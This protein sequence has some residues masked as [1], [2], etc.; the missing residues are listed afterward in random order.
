MLT[1][2]IIRVIYSIIVCALIYGFIMFIR[3]AKRAIKAL[4][5]YIANN[6]KPKDADESEVKK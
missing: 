5:I 1:I 2:Y 6:T 3:V 4:D